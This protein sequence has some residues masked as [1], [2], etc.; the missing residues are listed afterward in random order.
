MEDFADSLCRLKL[1]YAMSGTKPL[2]AARVARL[3]SMGRQR[4]EGRRERDFGMTM[5]LLEVLDSRASDPA[6]QLY[7]LSKSV[8]NANRG[9]KI[10]WG[11]SRKLVAGDENREAGIRR[12]NHHTLCD[13]I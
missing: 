8:M 2:Q 10:R 13:W 7:L 1:R 9:T 5:L 6:R 12:Q 11:R 4:R 3:S